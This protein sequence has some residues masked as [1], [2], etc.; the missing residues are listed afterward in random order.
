MKAERAVRFSDLRKM[1]EEERGQV[2]GALV[3][4][5]RSPAN[6]RIAE[7]DARIAEFERRYELPSADMVAEIE[8]GTR[9]ETDDIASWLML[10]RVRKR[11]TANQPG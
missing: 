9:K 2:L 10:I 7:L 4:E 3:E 5:A 8:S 1:S 6:G 11:V